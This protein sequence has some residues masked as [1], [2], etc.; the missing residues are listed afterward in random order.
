MLIYLA[1]S[2]TLFL[3]SCNTPLPFGGAVDLTQA[4][5]GKLPSLDP[6]VTFVLLYREEELWLV[7][8]LPC[9]T[10]FFQLFPLYTYPVRNT[11]VS[12]GEH[13]H[14]PLHGSRWT[15]RRVQQD[16]AQVSSITIAS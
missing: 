14:P 11:L 7:W 13:N 2:I 9:S 1:W 3:L 16:A 10:L 5:D 12:Q 15:Q 8:C 6:F 4:H